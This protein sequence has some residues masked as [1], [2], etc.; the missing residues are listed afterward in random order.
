MFEL[1]EAGAEVRGVCR[2]GRAEAPGGV[3][4]QA[5]DISQW[6]DAQRLC[7]GAAVVY[8][9][10][11]LDYPLWLEQWPWIV[12]GLINGAG[13]AGAKLVFADNLYSYG[14]Q[15]GPL[16]EDLPLTRYGKKPTLRARLT[17]ELL[18]VHASERVPTAIVRAS[19]F[20]GPRVRNA[21]LGERVFPMA[22]AGKPAQLIGDIDQPHT[23]T[24][25]PD[26]ARALIRVADDE[27]AY[28]QIWHVPSAPAHT[29]RQIVEKI[30]K[31]AGNP[32]RIR[33]LPEWLM[34][35]MKL[36]NPLL[37][38]LEEM[39]FIWDR[40]YIMEHEKFARHFGDEWTSLDDGLAATLDWFRENSKQI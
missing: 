33:V 5:G 30:Y 8:S 34:G 13:T 37:R 14:P 20:Y 39:R 35:I 17:E 11:G 9:C 38:E 28:G 25:V 12:N 7:E 15:D 32:A 1:R 24:Y 22:L 3:E 29:T 31:L 18:G 23:Y 36:F 2:S 4:V 40:P 6:K 16:T 10:V 19:D 27:A 21:M 26:F